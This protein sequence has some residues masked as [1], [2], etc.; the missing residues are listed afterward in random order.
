VQTYDK[1]IA[2]PAVIHGCERWNLRLREEYRLKVF[3][4]KNLNIILD[5]RGMRM[6]NGE[7]IIM[8][9]FID[10]IVHTV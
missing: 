6:G 7:S 2:L 3:E 9:N 8:R 10:S 1:T 4:K 5:P